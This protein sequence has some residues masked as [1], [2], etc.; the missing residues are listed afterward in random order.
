MSYEAIWKKVLKPE[1][2]I[3]EEFTLGKR[4]ILLVQIMLGVLGLIFLPIFWI[5]SIILFLLT[6]FVGWYL[7]Q[8]NAYAF[9]EKR[10]LIHKGWL[11]THLTSIDYDKI[12]D[13]TVAEPL[14]D[15]LIC[16]TG[17][18]SINTAGTGFHE[19]VLRHIESPYEIKKKLDSVREAK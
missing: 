19:V 13:V 5:F 10:V 16:K 4:Y 6:F 1:E 15:R 8:A 11:S 18:M 12:T 3:I 9:T 17:H 7:K 14:F 2:N